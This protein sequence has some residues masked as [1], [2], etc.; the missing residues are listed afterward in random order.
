M[1]LV[2]VIVQRE[3]TYVAQSLLSVNVRQMFC[4]LEAF[5]QLGI[6]SWHT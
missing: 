4:T 2:D 1:L 6:N 5:S 3:R